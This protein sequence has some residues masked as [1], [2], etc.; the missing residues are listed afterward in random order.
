MDTMAKTKPGGHPVLYARGRDFETCLAAGTLC[1]HCEQP[2]RP[3]AICHADG[4]GCL[5]VCEMC[6]R[7]VLRITFFNPGE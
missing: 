2:L 5:L 4:A 3:T 7:D 6:H 1:P